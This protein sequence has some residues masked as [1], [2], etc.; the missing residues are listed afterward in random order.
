M[1]GHQE[2]VQPGG[3]GE[4]DGAAAVPV[5]LV[6]PFLPTIAASFRAVSRMRA[7]LNDP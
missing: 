5:P 7:L 4:E 6:H 3:G 2:Q 1:A